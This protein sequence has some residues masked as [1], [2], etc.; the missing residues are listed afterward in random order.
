MTGRAAGRPASAAK[1]SA[2]C[3]RPGRRRQ[4]AA[5]LKPRRLRIT[6]SRI[7]KKPI[8]LPKGVTVKVA[9]RRGRGARARR[10]AAAG[11]CR[12]ASCSRRTTARCVATLER[13]DRQLRQ[14]PWPGAQ[15]GGQRRDRRHRR[16]QEGARHRRRRLPRGAEGQAGAL[17]ARL[18]APG[19]VRHPDRHRHRD[20]QADA[21]HRD[22][23]RSAAGRPGGGEHPPACASPTRTSRR[24]CATRAKC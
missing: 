13:E 21:R 7:G 3:G 12:P 19:G 11:A 1:C 24:A 16:L 6:M 15:P 8:P 5:G 4:L 23:R 2:T 14:V 18:L 9:R 10:A 22:R 20:R 17:R